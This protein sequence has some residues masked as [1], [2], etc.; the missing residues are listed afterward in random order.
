[1]KKKDLRDVSFRQFLCQ[2]S[3]FPLLLLTKS[4][5]FGSIDKLNMHFD[6]VYNKISTIAV[7]IFVQFMQFFIFL[8]KI[9]WFLRLIDQYKC[10]ILTNFSWKY[11]NR[12]SILWF[13]ELENLRRKSLFGR[14]S[15]TYMQ[16]TL[17]FIVLRRP[18]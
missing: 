9:W 1:M 8:R 3:I 2:I 12:L 16:D 14:F 4:Q 11:P 5:F 13:S 10:I 15:I 17:Y 7:S 6:K 18:R